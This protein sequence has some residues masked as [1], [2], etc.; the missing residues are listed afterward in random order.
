MSEQSLKDKTVK[1]V[2]WSAIDNIV[3]YVVSF[4][5]SIVLARLLSPDDYGLIGIVAIFTA[6]CNT[7]IN[8]GLSSALIRKKDVTDDD[9]STIFVV[10][11]MM[12]VT[13]YGIIFFCAPLIAIFFE[14]DELV[15]LTRVSSVSMIIGALSLVQQTR[16][17]KKIDF[18]TQTKIT[19]IA[20]ISSGLIGVLMAI[21]EYGV[22]ALVAQGI[23]SNGVRTILLWIY[24]RWAPRLYFSVK[25]FN[26]LFGFGWKLMLSSLLDSIWKELY[27]VVVGK[28]YSPATLGQYTRAKHFSQLFS[29]NLTN[30]I[31]RVSY[32]VLSDIQDN[33]ERMVSAYRKIIKTTMFVTAASMFALA[34]VSEPLLYC[35]IGPKWHEAAVFLPFIC[36]TG[37]MYPLHAI[38]LNM[39]QLQ[40][41][42]DI[43]L[44]LEIIKKIIAIA[45]LC[46]GI[47]IGIMPMLYVSLVTSIVNFF[48]NSSYSGR[49]IGYSSWMQI[50]DIAPSYG[51]ATIMA[52]SVYF[53]KYLPISNWVILSLQIV[54]GATVFFSVSRI[55]ELAEYEEIKKIV[56]SLIQKKF[57]SHIDK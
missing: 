47:F 1:G 29:S 36:L 8:Y 3:Q 34:A 45:P 38:N 7:L 56:I 42:S 48:M 16:L 9:F 39:L 6:I 24:N 40:G 2:G 57:P 46:V 50:K 53:L 35:L 33:R 22:W 12:S 13:L 27:Q 52:L 51:V 17:T 11:L 55:M 4:V 26:E 41:R 43:F 32:P 44:I 15:L 14:R 28:Y 23:V 19:L 49:L 25:S 54:V 10:N 30:V 20:S 31:Q 5:V 21:F 18:K 37:S